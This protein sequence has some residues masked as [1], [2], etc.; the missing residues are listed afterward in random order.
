MI[1]GKKQSGQV[2]QSAGAP[3]YVLSAFA[4]ALGELVAC[5]SEG[6]P[7]T[8]SRHCVPRPFGQTGVSG[9]QFI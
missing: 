2:A 1:H 6:Y 7:G 4:H 5:V 3:G 9:E 8:L